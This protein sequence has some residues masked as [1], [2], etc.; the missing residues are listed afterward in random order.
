[1]TYRVAPPAEAF[2]PEEPVLS[3]TILGEDGRP[4]PARF[5]V[6]LEGTEYVPR[7]LGRHGLRFLSRHVHH[8]H[9]FVATY[10][11]GSGP[12]EV[13]LPPGAAGGTV[14]V[15]RGYETL[16]TKRRFDVVDGRAEVTIRL[17]RWSNLAAQGW[18]AADA[19]LHYDR[20]EAAQDAD[21][22]TLLAGDDLEV[23]HFLT[24]KGGN[25]QGL[26]GRQYAYGAAGEASDGRRL[27]RPGAEMRGGLQGHILLLGIERLVHPLAI[28]RFSGDATRYSYPPLHD[29]LVEA[30]A[31]GGIAGVAHGG[32]YGSRPTAVLDAVLG[33]AGFFELANTHL[34]HTSLWYELATA[35]WI[36]PPSAGTDLPGFSLREPWQPL[37]GQARMYA[38][39]GGAVDFASFKAA[40]ERG[41]TWITTGPLLSFTVAEAGPGATV[42][43]PAGGGSVE[44][45]A[46]LASPRPMEALE[47]VAN[48]VPVA[49]A[50]AASRT[51]GIYRLTVR[52]TLAI[53]GSSWLAARGRG[54]DTTVRRG[55][56]RVLQPTAAH[57][58]AVQVLVGGAPIRSRT[59]AKA[60]ADRLAADR[61]HYAEHG[62]FAEPGHRDAFLALFDR[63][64]VVAAER[65][66]ESPAP[67]PSTR[68]GGLLLAGAVVLGSG[69]LVALAARRRRA[70][71]P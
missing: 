30:R 61:Q 49:A 22:L 35:G 68:S 54:A 8:A 46:E 62:S 66:G 11:R 6:F 67:A 28:G 23:G 36:L 14:H 52:T 18:I 65:L 16:P 71:R 29:A 9:D 40:L 48:G 60:L 51:D 2:G 21:W 15:V 63:A 34:Y 26:W 55:R 27:I 50:T 47:I 38:R 43:L 64:H 20:Q 58:A 45:H 59:D 33:G 13:P 32:F 17:E 37:L 53:D 7:A 24:A 41:E 1:V 10:A 44:V 69:T 57:S 3:L 25:V 39:T 70:R 12:V 56:S 31:Q 4:V 19:H 5:S 42:E